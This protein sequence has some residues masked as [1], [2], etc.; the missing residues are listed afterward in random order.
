MTLHLIEKNPECKVY[1]IVFL[2]GMKPV[3]SFAFRVPIWERESASL[4]LPS[5]SSLRSACGHRALL[6]ALRMA[7]F[8]AQIL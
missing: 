3:L 1:P 5:L 2:K 7:W 8:I 4:L 6:R